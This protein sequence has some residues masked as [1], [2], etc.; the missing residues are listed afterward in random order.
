MKNY[1]KNNYS[2]KN[3]KQYKKKSE[4]NFYSENSNSSKKYNRFFRSSDK[5]NNLN[6]LNESNKNKSSYSSIKKSKPIYQSNKKGQETYQDSSNK[7]NYDDWI[8]G[9]HSVFEALNSERAINRIWCTSE[10]FSSEKFYILLKELKSRG[11]L[12]EEVSWNRLSQLTF[13]ASHQGIALQLACSKTIS[14]EQ[15]INFSKDN[16]AYP[17][18]HPNRDAMVKNLISEGVEVRP[19]ICRSMG[20]QPF[21]VKLYGKK[22]LKNADIVDKY[23]MYIPNHPELSSN[24]ILKVCDIINRCT[25]Q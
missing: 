3:N 20:V 21:Y 2:G 8:W 22:I 11:V 14:L 1:S 6:N 13:G 4:S 18:I 9:K 10:I 24:D 25:E 23:G 15:L 5:N 16:F 17:I 7:R 12:I 19:M